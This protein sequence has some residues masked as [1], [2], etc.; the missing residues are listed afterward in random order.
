[1]SVRDPVQALVL[2]GGGANGAYEVGILK[3]LLN[4][5]CK[6][7]GK[8][9]PDYFFGT[10]V[11]AF[12]ASFLVSQW[13]EYGPAAVA[14]LERV[15]IE[16]MAGDTRSNGVFRFRGDP[17]Y[18]L[19]PASYL[20][21][22]FRPF[23]EMARD[24]AYLSWEGLQ[25][26]V[27]FTTERQETAWERAANLFDFSAVVSLEPYDQTIRNTINFGSIRQSG[28]R[29]KLRIFATNWITGQLRIFEN[30]DM[31]ENL[32]P[33]AIQASS[34]I[35]GVFPSVSVGAEVFVDGSVLMSTPLRPALDVGADILHVVYL[36]PDVAAMPL[37]TLDSTVASTYRLQTISWAALIDREI[38]RA[39][40][41][42]R[43]LA[44]FNRIRGGG[45]TGREELDE[46][47]KGAITVLG[48]DHPETY[49]PVTIHRYHPRDELGSGPLSLLNLDRDHIDDLIQRGF[50]DASLHNC[51][52]E[53]CVLPDPELL[54]AEETGRSSVST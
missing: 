19:N 24:S 37:S 17:T 10:S 52:K 2:S 22:P 46:L 31:T 38:D 36:D 3:A 14:N 35:P 39:R 29:R 26:A 18:Y 1:M 53:G 28:D 12:N 4:G 16:A 25:R 47:A 7:V 8:V 43:G 13:E 6:P 41:I 20:P 49:R 50:A 44:V 32:G 23:I 33:L 9:D 51:E 15:W 11:G 5:K 30:R 45:T 34:A 48:G 21:N 54:E 42:N 40:R 27:Y